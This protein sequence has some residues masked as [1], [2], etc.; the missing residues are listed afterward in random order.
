MRLATVITFV[1]FLLPATTRAGVHYSGEKFNELPANWR[2]FLLDH[3]SLR[4]IGATPG[5]GIPIHILREQYLA[6]AEK[7]ETQAKTKPLT[8]DQLADLGAIY[9]R[10]NLP[11]KAIDILRPAARQYPDHFR[12]LSN[13][14]TA[15]QMSGDLAGADRSLV[16]AIRV[17]PPVWK[18]FE[19]A[20]LKLVR[21]R[22]REA[23]NPN[24]VDD[25]FGVKFAE[26]MPPEERKKLPTDDVALVQQL[27]L[28]LPADG[29]LL[30]QLGE[31]ANAHGD[32]RTT[33]SILEGC[34]SEFALAAPEVRLHRKQY[35]EA[36]DA[37]GKLP[38][39]EHAKF[40]GDIA[41]KS[42]R[43][44][45]RE[46]DL[47]TLPEIR[48]DGTNLLPWPVLNETTIEKPFKPNFLKHLRQLDGK[49][50]AITGYMQPV[51]MDFEVSGFMLVEYPVGCWFCETPEP[52]GIVF[53]DLGEGKSTTVRRNRV[54]I[55]G[56]LKLN[57]SDPEDFLYTIVGAKVSDPD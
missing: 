36:A 29:R 10:L 46:F 26:K 32:V 3:R 34:V 47:T 49:K 15:W 43:A 33:A 17:A 55:T 42:T 41:F 44:L 5:A 57:S 12:I 39:A 48:P 14:G 13:L 51:S 22:V 54:K 35:R 27:A 37:I 18:K 21:L 24:A 53:A 19:E 8:A 25:L 23:K 1:L 6:L 40:R 11:A 7:L 52:S 28:W 20:Q 31:L 2:G 56:V 38:D 16:E 50:V 9:L 4:M 30:W 45:Q